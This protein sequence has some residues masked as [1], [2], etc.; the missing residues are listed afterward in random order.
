MA[1]A[2]QNPKACEYYDDFLEQINKPRDVEPIKRSIPII[3]TLHPSFWKSSTFLTWQIIRLNEGYRNFIDNIWKNLIELENDFAI[4]FE[5]F[6]PEQGESIGHWIERDNKSLKLWREIET[7]SLVHVVTEQAAGNPLTNPLELKTPIPIPY[8]V[9][10]PKPCLITR[11]RSLPAETLFKKKGQPPKWDRNLLIY[12]LSQAGMKNMEI[13]RLL[14]GV[15]KSTENWPRI[16]KHPKLVR[17]ADIKK[18][19]RNTV[20]KAYPV[21]QSGQ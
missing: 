13:A 19:I 6:P 14:F 4:F 5:E 3:R 8:T 17:I 9:R 11:V 1:N 15:K 18:V 20:S 10:F 7:I 21:Y 2:D 16:L 12:E